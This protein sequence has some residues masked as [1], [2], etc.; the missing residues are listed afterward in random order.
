MKGDP[1]RYCTSETS[2]AGIEFGI[3]T[4]TPRRKSLVT[5]EDLVH[6]I[7]QRDPYHRVP[8]STITA[9]SRD[10]PAPIPATWVATR[11]GMKSVVATFNFALPQ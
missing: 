6:L 5:L 2:H 9:R 7:G 1:T 10:R 11:S 3:G 4:I 8:N